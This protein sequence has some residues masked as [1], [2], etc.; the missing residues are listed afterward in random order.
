MKRYMIIISAALCLMLGSCGT[1]IR[2]TEFE[3]EEA[4]VSTTAAQ[5]TADS[6]LNAGCC[7]PETGAGTIPEE[8]SIPSCC[9]PELSQELSQTGCCCGG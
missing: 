3:P 8:Y 9:S 2:Q 6:T 4:A 1:D 5:E 7:S